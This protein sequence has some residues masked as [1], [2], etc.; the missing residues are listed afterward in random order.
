M[1]E[2][3]ASVNGEASIL[4]AVPPLLSFSRLVVG[5]DNIR[6]DVFFS[7]RW[8]EAA[9]QYL[10]EQ[11][12]H[13]AQPY[14]GGLNPSDP[15]RR[16]AAA[17]EFRN[18]TSQLLQVS[19]QRAKEENNLEVDLLA[20]L[21]LLKW[22]L[23]DMQ[24]QFAQLGITCKGIADKQTSGLGEDNMKA[25]VLRSKLAEFA[26][27]KRH[28]LAAVGENLFHIFEELEESTLRPSRTAL[29]GSP[30]DELYRVARN[31][32][33]YL[34]NPNDSVVHLEHYVMLGHFVGDAD[35]EDRI[36]EV[37]AQL[38]REQGLAGSGW[39]QLHG[40][41]Q[42]QEK[43]GD[44]LQEVNRQ[45]RETE[46][47]LEGSAGEKAAESPR[48]GW[49]GAWRKK[50]EAPLD[51]AGLERLARS[52]ETQREQY[53]RSVEAL[54]S[55][56]AFW[57]QQEEVKLTGLLT[58]SAN[59][60]R[61]FGAFSPTGKSQPPT[62]EQKALL[63]KLSSR[64]EQ[65]GMLKSILASYHL[66]SLYKEFC[67]PLNPQQLKLALVD[68]RGWEQFESL[69]DQ[70]PTQ[71]FPVEKL[72]ELA[73]RL[74]KLSR[75]DAE[76]LLVR[77]THDLTRLRRDKLHRQQ[78]LALLVKIHLLEDEKTLQVSRLNRSLYEFLLPEEREGGEEHVLT[79]VVLKA[80]VR[81]STRITQ[82][83]LSR[84]LNPATHFS[85]NFYEPVRK[86][87]ARYSAAKI[88]IEGDALILGLY[89][90]ESNKAYQRPVA[91]ACLLAKEIVGG[92]QVYNQRAR[93]ND[94][95][96]LELGLGIAYHGG[97]PHYWDDGES[98]IMISGALNL[99]D[100]LASCTRLARKLVGGDQTPFRVFLFQSYPTL[101]AGEEEE[102]LL[103]RYNVMGV[104]L[105]EEGFQ[106]LQQ[107]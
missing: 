2:S 72:E 9:R 101:G 19:L 30:A 44:Q 51:R 49:L 7:P 107:E 37:V 76:S 3:E 43:A 48:Q 83:L 58:D 22:L 25:F 11:I 60:E 85:F 75:G 55:K 5:V 78:L 12:L 13:H 46:R 81:D 18:R 57:R 66:K 90:T 50:G 91:K 68:R 35:D 93:A 38:L 67:P 54:G 77:F 34:D 82:H 15:R 40:L 29:F 86:L 63:Q 89:E 61:F 39:Q 17:A 96:V 10:L 106:K 52:L 14:L 33:I 102:E 87:M 21:A 95:P 73:R 97:P 65:A 88:F 1:P 80:D 6:Y 42:E 70:F 45:L 59:A 74:R 47:A 69:L 4:V 23:A 62:A 26:S 99:S 27:N 79:H 104:A 103:I 53:T 28:I 56:V 92:C 98:R 94:L 16:S 36:T 32:L 100:R 71:N 64:F 31:R 105:N 20:R 84:N 41:E 8:K 24:Q